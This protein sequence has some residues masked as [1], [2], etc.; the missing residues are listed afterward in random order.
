[1]AE[2]TSRV[3]FN[4]DLDNEISFF[5]CF[6]HP[7]FVVV[8]THPSPYTVGEEIHVEIRKK[9]TRYTLCTPTPLRA[10]LSRGALVAAEGIEQ[11]QLQRIQARL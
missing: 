5:A 1:M 10:A 11:V 3:Y 9:V 8:S 2:W 4:G 6:F 7:L